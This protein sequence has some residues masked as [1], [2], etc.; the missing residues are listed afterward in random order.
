MWERVEERARARE[1]T[2]S[3]G[4][5][6]IINASREQTVL[7]P[8]CCP[9]LCGE[10]RSCR[11]SSAVCCLRDSTVTDRQT[12]RRRNSTTK[13][14]Q[15]NKTS[16]QTT[17]SLNTLK[18]QMSVFPLRVSSGVG[19]CCMDLSATMQQ[20]TSSESSHPAPR[21]CV[22]S[23]RPYPSWWRWCASRCLC[24]GCTLCALTVWSAGD[25]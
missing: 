18:F 15:I 23:C 14:R 20:Q 22:T 21:L 19:V 16:K 3:R 24:T 2:E 8:S 9:R 7:E 17:N 13:W 11:W 6:R 1:M 10:A 5:V 4:Q 12:D 25:D